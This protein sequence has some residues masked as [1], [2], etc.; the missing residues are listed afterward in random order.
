MPRD[1]TIDD[2]YDQDAVSEMLARA[3]ASRALLRAVDGENIVVVD[4]L[5]PTHVAT[6]MREDLESVDDATW[7]RARLDYEEVTHDFDA[8]TSAEA[9]NQF[10]RVAF[11]L[12]RAAQAAAASGT[13]QA[14]ETDFDQLYPSFTA[15]RYFKRDGIEPHDDVAFVPVELADGGYEVHARAFAGVYYL[16]PDDWDV[17]VDGGALEDLERDG[18]LIEPKFNRFVCFSVPRSHAVREVKS[19]T[20]T[21]RSIF[22]WW[23]R[24]AREDE[25]PSDYFDDTDDENEEE[26]ENKDYDQSEAAAVPAKR[27]KS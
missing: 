19:E 7:E 1:F 4:D 13:G 6:A 16:T 3:G 18:R 20:K 24:P 26:G 12:Q 14:H 17:E 22:G 11:A 5:L 27:R 21:R 9:V 23:Y 8:T 10:T 25:V 2:L 15:S